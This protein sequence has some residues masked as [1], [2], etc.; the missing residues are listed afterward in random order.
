[1]FLNKP[2]PYSISFRHHFLIAAILG[3]IVVFII[4]F[5]HPLGSN[6]FTSPFKI[7]YFTGYGIINFF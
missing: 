6:N 1:M 2:F 4:V 3:I 5:L 7:L